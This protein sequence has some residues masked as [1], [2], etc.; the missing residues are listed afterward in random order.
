MATG[1]SMFLFATAS[2]LTFELIQAPAW[3]SFIANRGTSNIKLIAD[4][5]MALKLCVAVYL[6]FPY[7]LMAC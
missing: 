1:C 7:V 2:V 5:C 3:G 6:H 4:P